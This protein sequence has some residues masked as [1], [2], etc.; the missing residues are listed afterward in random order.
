[1][2]GTVSSS[3]P[4]QIHH[5]TSPTGKSYQVS[6]TVSFGRFFI[7]KDASSSASD[8]TSDSEYSTDQLEQT[9][10]NA[11]MLTISNEKYVALIDD[12]LQ[13]GFLKSLTELRSFMQAHNTVRKFH[14]DAPPVEAYVTGPKNDEI[15][16]CRYNVGERC[17]LGAGLTKQEA[18]DEAGLRMLLAYKVDIRTLK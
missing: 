3:A 8:V 9:P 5:L 15:W 18:K 12:D 1:M 10:F 16:H 6:A 7:S 14:L 4:K 11:Y 17:Y 2:P 13:C